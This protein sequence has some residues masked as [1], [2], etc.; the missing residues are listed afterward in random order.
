MVT[1]EKPTEEE[2]HMAFPEMRDPPPGADQRNR[3]RI[4]RQLQ[5]EI[6]GEDAAGTSFSEQAVTADVSEG[7]CRFELLR[8]LRPNALILIRLTDDRSGLSSA[9]RDQVFKVAWIEQSEHGW[10]IG[11][12]TLED[13]TPWAMIFRDE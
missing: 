11:V 1:T 6:S 10:A 2:D 5:I 9:D 12:V 8:P 4:R 7:G 3:K 13:K